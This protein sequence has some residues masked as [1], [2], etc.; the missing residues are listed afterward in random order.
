MNIQTKVLVVLSFL[1]VGNV[2]S[3]I[4]P[5]NETEFRGTY[6]SKNIRELWQV[7]SMEFQTKQPMIPPPLRQVVCD[8]Y[9]DV[10]RKLLTLEQSKVSTPGQAKVLTETLI[11]ECNKKYL[12]TPPIS[13]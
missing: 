10:I 5:D 7:C 9:V 13:A 2:I 4:T 11:R 8:C 3:A 12:D 1:L 6:P